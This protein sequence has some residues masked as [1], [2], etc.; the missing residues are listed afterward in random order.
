MLIIDAVC[1]AIKGAAPE[2]QRGVNPWFMLV[3]AVVFF[4]LIL[5]AALLIKTL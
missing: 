4:V 1:R 3:A 5:G 2:P